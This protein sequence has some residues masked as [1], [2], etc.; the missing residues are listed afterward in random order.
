M[1]TLRHWLVLA[2]APTPTPSLDISLTRAALA[3]GFEGVWVGERLA[4][5][6]SARLAAL[7]AAV[8]AVGLGLGLVPVTARVRDHL[9]DTL[10]TLSLLAPGRTSLAFALPTTLS[11]LARPG[12]R[13]ALGEAADLARRS[14]VPVCAAVHDVSTSVAAGRLVDRLVLRG[15]DPETVSR[16][17]AATR[18]LPRPPEVDVWLDAAG[19]GD[20]KALSVLAPIVAERLA[21]PGV[22][23]HDAARAVARRR[24]PSGLLGD[25]ERAYALG[26]P[27]LAAA[28]VPEEFVRDTCLV[29]EGM[30]ARVAAYEAAGATRLAVALHDT[31]DA[32]TTLAAVSETALPDEPV[33]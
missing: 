24:G 29:G 13:E 17:H 9:Q 1:T 6:S 11:P 31:G 19:G 12:W 4:G 26:R 14:G 8:P 25:V 32:D 18:A 7:A 3:H 15:V 21:V 2:P 20:G 27:D 16:V 28:G 23:G 10:T 33:T 5:D 22:A 30:S